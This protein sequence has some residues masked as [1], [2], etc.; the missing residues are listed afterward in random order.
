[1]RTSLRAPKQR[2]TAR[3][4]HS[5]DLLCAYRKKRK[6]KRKAGFKS[7]MYNLKHGHFGGKQ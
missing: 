3:C 4:L 1:M 5:A 2:K 7:K 6:A